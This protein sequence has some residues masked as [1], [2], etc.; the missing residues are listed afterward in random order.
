MFPKSIYA[1]KFFGNQFQLTTL[2]GALI[3]DKNL[4][5]N[6]RTDVK[7]RIFPILITYWSGFG[8]FKQNQD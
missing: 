8:I 7:I 3:T 1:L 4:F 5:E 2:F 6:I